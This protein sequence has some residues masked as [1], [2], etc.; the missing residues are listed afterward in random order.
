MEDKEIKLA[1]IV[2]R[3]T[4]EEYVVM[5]LQR[6]ENTISQNKNILDD[7][8]RDNLI[9]TKSNRA[10]NQI[11]EFI[12]KHFEFEFASGNE[13]FVSYGHVG[14]ESKELKQLIERAI[15]NAKV[16]EED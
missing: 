11:V 12:F 13:L 7:L 1:E 5:Q 15:E 16:E 10:L 3:L 4:A 2:E 9:L 14:V 6:A 8:E